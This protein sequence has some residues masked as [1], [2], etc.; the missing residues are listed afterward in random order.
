MRRSLRFGAMALV[1]MGSV[2]LAAAD[3][4]KPGAP[5]SG[6]TS[7]VGSEPPPNTAGTNSG[8][9]SNGPIGATPQTMPSKYSEANAAADQL[10][11]MARALPLSDDQKRQ[12]LDAVGRAPG[13]V[14]AISAKPAQELRGAVEL[15]DLPPGLA[16]QIPAVRG[17]KYVKLPD[18]VILVAPSSRVVVGEIT[19]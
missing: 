11:T 2:G 8:A 5:K 13:P 10:P 18:K 3:A 9:A 15:N 19:E 12:I 17:Y 4:E 6:D 7:P 14:A 16:E 1:L